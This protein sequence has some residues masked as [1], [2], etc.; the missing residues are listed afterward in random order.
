MG[1]TSCASTA[2]QTDADDNY[3]CPEG[4]E[5]DTFCADLVRYARDPDTGHCCRYESQCAAPTGWKT[6]PSQSACEAAGDDD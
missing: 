6:F 2:G 3:R 5:L 1:L 4:R